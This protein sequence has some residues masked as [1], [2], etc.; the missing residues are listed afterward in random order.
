MK[1][2]PCV[3]SVS[4]HAGWAHVVC[5]AAPR[6]VPIVVERRRVKT[7]DAGLP[8]MPYHHESLGMSVRAADA[9]IARVRRSIADCTARALHAVVSE[10]TPS[11]TVV[12][13]AIRESRFAGLPESVATVRQ[14]YALQC[15]ADGMMYQLA[16]CDAARDLG[17][18]VHQCRRGDETARVA[19]RLDVHR[20]EV[21]TFVRATGRPAG[22][23]WTE[24]HRRAFAAGIA[25]LAPH[26]GRLDLVDRR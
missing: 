8:T 9:L 17:L 26:A 19:A 5:V 20:D 4:D 3:V 16:L 21:D 11:Y 14:S 22:P 2:T 24:E 23:P 12:A 15:A 7:I 13:F 6:H 18:D 10:L 1:P 25:A